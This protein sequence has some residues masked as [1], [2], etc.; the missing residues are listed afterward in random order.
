MNARNLGFQVGTFDI[1]LCG[2]MGWS[3]CFDFENFRFTRPDTKAPEIRR[4]LRDGGMFL[5]CAWEKQEDISWMENAVLRHYPEILEN[6]LYHEQ[7]PIGMS[8]E[9]AQGYEMIFRSAGFG[10]IG[11]TRS[12]MTFA[13]IDEEEWWWQ[14]QQL[15]WK[16]VLEGIGNDVLQDLK[17]AIFED[18]QSH[19][20]GDGFHFE[21]TAFFVWGF[22]S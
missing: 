7:R 5:C 22:K 17:D 1:A 9:N 11:I 3:D 15:G 10:Y 21:K 20:V 18:L 16:P 4:V 6:Q 19:K 2:F 14:M 12:T 8:Y 13:S